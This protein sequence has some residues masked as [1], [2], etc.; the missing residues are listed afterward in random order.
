MFYVSLY[1]IPISHHYGYGYRSHSQL[2]HRT[3]TNLNFDFLIL[4][5][6]TTT[7]QDSCS[8][9]DSTFGT[10]IFIFTFC[11][12]LPHLLSSYPTQ[13]VPDDF[14]F[15]TY[16]AVVNLYHSIISQLISVI[17]SSRVLWYIYT[18]FF[19]SRLL[20]VLLVCVVIEIQRVRCHCI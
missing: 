19:F 15:V 6:I 13:V 5:I 2:P 8:M 20:L 4:L 14:M 10:T 11:V 7:P 17:L 18:S 9:L 3:G 16:I 12:S 1:L